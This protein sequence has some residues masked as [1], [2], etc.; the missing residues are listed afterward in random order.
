MAAGTEVVPFGR[1]PGRGL[2][3]TARG[4]VCLGCLSRSDKFFVCLDAVTRRPLP[5]HSPL[6]YARKLN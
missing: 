4:K 2:D 5:P 6:F 3:A 1:T